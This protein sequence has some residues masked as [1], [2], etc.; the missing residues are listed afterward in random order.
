MTSK[1]F[2]TGFGPFGDVVENPSQ[3]LATQIGLPHEVL[4]VGFKDVDQFL[5][6]F[7]PAGIST[8]LLLGV[9]AKRDRITPEFF[10]RNESGKTVDVRGEARPGK[11]V[12]DGPHLRETT[13]WN[14]NLVSEWT[15]EL[16][17]RASFDAGT[18]LCNYIYFQALTSF[19][20]LNVGFLHVPSEALLEFTIQ[21]ETLRTIVQAL[22][23]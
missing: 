16:P 15:T 17:V 6:R 3:K 20:N 10:A 14:S 12:D 8:L 7:D 11:I 21:L 23:G 9:A 18:Y 4:P 22:E 19:P 2:V 5:Q 1:I 13:L